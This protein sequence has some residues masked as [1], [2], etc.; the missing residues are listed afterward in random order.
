MT[1]KHIPWNMFYEDC[2]NG[3]WLCNIFDFWLCLAVWVSKTQAHSLHWWNLYI[4]GVCP[5]EIPRSFSTSLQ[6]YLSTV[7]QATATNIPEQTFRHITCTTSLLW[8]QRSVVWWLEL[9]GDRAQT[10]KK[11]V[12]SVLQYKRNRIS[13]CFQ[14]SA[15][16]RLAMIKAPNITDSIRCCL[17]LVYH[18]CQNN[19]Q[20][21]ARWYHNWW[22]NL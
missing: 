6:T 17:E 22:F 13:P 5:E 7:N 18:N 11:T 19:C 3:F 8:R 21:N 16:W 4:V 9:W 12:T 2:R 1:R 10:F 14:R 15:T 20:I